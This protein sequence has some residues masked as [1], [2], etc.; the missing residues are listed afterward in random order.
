L[1]VPAPVAKPKQAAGRLL[2]SIG[3]FT[4]WS[5]WATVSQS[6]AFGSYPNQ[7][8]PVVAA[9]PP[10]PLEDLSGAW[11]QFAL[12]ARPVWLAMPRFHFRWGFAWRRRR[13]GRNWRSRELCC[14]APRRRHW[15]P[16]RHG[17]PSFPRE[18]TA[19][20]PVPPTRH[21]R[22]RMWSARHPPLW[23]R[24]LRHPR[25]RAPRDR[26]GLR[27]DPNCLQGGHGGAVQVAGSGKPLL[28]LEL[29]DKPARFGTEDAVLGHNGTKHLRQDALSPGDEG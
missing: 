18:R 13:R 4:H 12:F 6:L 14:R 9:H 27:T 16:W 8:N 19:R 22:L 25:L 11:R 28:G 24:P 1:P 15:L 26:R 17:L 2:K 21:P 10:T 23:V 5:T 20:V 3:T 7:D 29:R